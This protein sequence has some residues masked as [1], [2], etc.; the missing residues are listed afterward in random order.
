MKEKYFKVNES[1][2]SV[3]ELMDDRTAGKF[4]KSVCNYAFYGDVCPI[5]GGPV[6]TVYSRIVGFFTPIR[7]YSKPRLAEWKLREWHNINGE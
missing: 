2:K 4:I 3:I 6:D 1:I 5:C 7:S